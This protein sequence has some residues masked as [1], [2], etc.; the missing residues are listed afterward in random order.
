MA[1]YDQGGG[2]ACGLQKECD[3]SCKCYTPLH[4]PKNNPNYCD[5]MAA[6]NYASGNKNKGRWWRRKAN[7][8]RSE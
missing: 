8:L 3:P 2:C 1:K 4:D 5:R 6:E 7:N